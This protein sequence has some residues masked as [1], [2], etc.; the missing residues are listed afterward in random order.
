MPSFMQIRPTP[1]EEFDKVGFAYLAIQRTKCASEVGV[2]YVRKSSAIQ[3]TY[4]FKVCEY[5]I[6]NVDVTGKNAIASIIAPP[7]EVHVR[8]L[9]WK[10]CV[11]SVPYKFQSCQHNSLAEMIFCCFS[12]NKPRPH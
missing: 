6:E 2:S 7:S 1:K 8:F 5:V 4:G 10:N 3:Q 12:C 9:V 11:L